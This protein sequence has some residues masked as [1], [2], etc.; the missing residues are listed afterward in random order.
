MLL[1]IGRIGIVF[2]ANIDCDD[3]VYRIPDIIVERKSKDDFEYEVNKHIL[4][5]LSVN[6][7]LY[8]ESMRKC[9]SDVDKK[10]IQNNFSIAE[11]LIKSVRRRNSTI[12]K[13][14]KE[15]VYRQLDFFDNLDS[16]LRPVSIKSLAN[17]LPIHESTIHR[18]IHGKTAATPRGIFPLKDLMPKEIKNKTCKNAVSDHSIKEY[19]KKLIGSE[20][21]NSPYSDSNIVSLLNSRG[22][23]ISRRTVSK[24]RSAMSIPNAFAR[25]NIYKIT[26]QFQTE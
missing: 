9:R 2:D 10:Y 20:P 21:K 12:L 3:C 5:Q 4:P 16:T 26:E 6:R 18:A 11:L 17:S 22:V 24:Y 25:T 23:N 7:E 14:L 19:M 8:D 13:I 15:L 1:E